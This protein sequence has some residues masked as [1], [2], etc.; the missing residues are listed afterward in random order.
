MTTTKVARVERERAATASST[1]KSTR[2]GYAHSVVN[3]PLDGDEDVDEGGAG[4]EHGR[5]WRMR[6]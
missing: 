3:G 6:R 4:G 2:K 5:G 1:V